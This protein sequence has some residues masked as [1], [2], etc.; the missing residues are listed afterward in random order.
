M[1]GGRPTEYG[2]DV[3]AKAKSAY[4]E[5]A[6]DK[7]V[8]DLIGV[9]VSTIYDWKLK[10]PEFS[11]ASKSWKANADEMVEN[12]LYKRAMGWTGP[13]TDIRVVDGEIVMTEIEKH[14]PPDPA[15]MIFWLKNRR[16][17]TWRDR[18]DVNHSGNLSNLTDDQV[19]E[20]HQE[21]MAKAQAELEAK[22]KGKANDEGK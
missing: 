14:Y 21:L 20:R 11:E 19:E 18:V 12:A 16:R 17:E 1:A 2:P 4:L 6:T 3:L 9:H 22:R 15:S 8:A 7:Q 10:R 5:G 13:D